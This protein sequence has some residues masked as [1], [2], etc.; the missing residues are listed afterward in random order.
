MSDHFA[1]RL[2]GNQPDH[3]VNVTGYLLP[4][5]EDKRPLLLRMPCSEDF[6][7]PIFSEEKTLE[8]FQQMRGAPAFDHIKMIENHEDFI[9]SIPKHIRIII[10]IRPHDNPEQKNKGHARFT[11]LLER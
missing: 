6:F 4:V 3:K 11:E 7:L 8:V 2:I 5:Y 10:N 9:E 1:P